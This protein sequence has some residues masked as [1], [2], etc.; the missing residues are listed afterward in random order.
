MRVAWCLGYPEPRVWMLTVYP[1]HD[2]TQMFSEHN[3]LIPSKLS[4]LP[5]NSTSTNVFFGRVFRGQL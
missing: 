3:I 4:S 1:R 2:T 5:N